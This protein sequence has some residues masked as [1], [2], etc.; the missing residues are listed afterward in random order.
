MKC[1]GKPT[2]E[3]FVNLLGWNTMTRSVIDSSVLVS[4]NVLFFFRLFVFLFCMFAYISHFTDASDDILD[5]ATWFEYLTHWDAIN[6][7]AYFGFASLAT[8]QSIKDPAISLTLLSTSTFGC[9]LHFTFELTAVSS[10]FVSILYWAALYPVEAVHAQGYW[11]FINVC[12][13]G[14]PALWMMLDVFLGC[15]VLVQFHLWMIYIY[16]I[17]YLIVNAIIT[18]DTMTPIYAILTYQSSTS[19]VWIVIS[20]VLIAAV[21]LMN[22]LF[23]RARTRCCSR[24]RSKSVVVFS[25]DA[26]PPAAAIV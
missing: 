2:K 13:H 10:W 9:F 23:I 19:V 18:V 21:W 7:A 4:Q 8:L 24:N 22:Y 25:K 1:C 16:F 17:V 26:K 12:M 20:L 6:V 15:G 5:S 14:L 3:C 11:A